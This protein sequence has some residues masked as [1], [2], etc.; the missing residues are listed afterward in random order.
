VAKFAVSR[1]PP[2]RPAVTLSPSPQV[3]EL[4]DFVLITGIAH[5]ADLELLAVGEL[6]LAA[7]GVHGGADTATFAEQLRDFRSVLLHVAAANQARQHWDITFSSGLG[8][9]P[10]GGVTRL[11]TIRWIGC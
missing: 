8:I 5:T 10:G 3:E 4:A 2:L 7:A 11:P 9:V 1:A 6:K